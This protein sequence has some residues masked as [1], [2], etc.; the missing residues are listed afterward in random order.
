VK[1]NKKKHTLLKA[2]EKKIILFVLLL[3]ICINIYAKDIYIIKSDNLD[4]Y[5]EVIESFKISLG[6]LS[7]YNIIVLDGKGLPEVIIEL[8]NNI[9]RKKP[10]AIITIGI[11]ST[12]I[13]QNIIDDIPIIFCGIY[14]WNKY[15]KK[16]KNITG[17]SMEINPEIIFQHIK[18]ISSQYKTL[19]ILY[20]AQFT[21]E[22]VDKFI[23]KSK[24][25][26]INIITNEVKTRQNQQATIRNL[27]KS[28]NYLEE[29]I[30]IFYLLSD[31]GIINIENF[32]YLLGKCN[33]FNIPLITYNEEFVRQGALASFSPDYANI[34][35]Q[36]AAILRK[37]ILNNITPVEIEISSPIGS[38]FVMNLT[39]AERLD[40]DLDLLRMI[41]NKIYY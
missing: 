9:K 33:N 1:N 28:M 41:V 22:K 29:K 13:F 24:K 4:T 3:L 18:L 32:N 34:G 21:Q 25:Y 7:D 10:E 2:M 35:S 31:P 23:E 40:L 27:I 15:I 5:K 20:D 38:S 39:V 6:A 36:L 11:Q 19:G 30:D 8:A 14:E 26:N 16:S 17:I 12:F 37:I